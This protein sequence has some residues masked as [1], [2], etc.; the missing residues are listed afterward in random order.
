MGYAIQS[1]GLFPTGAWRKILPPCRNYKNGHG[2][3]RRSYRRINGATGAGAKFAERYP[4]QLS[5]GQ[6]Q[7]VGVARAWL[8]IRKSY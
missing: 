7:R 2:P 8:P 3:D 5:G 4:H 1:I 6:Q